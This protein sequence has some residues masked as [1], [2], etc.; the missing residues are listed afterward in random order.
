MR[1]IGILLAL[2]ALLGGC[3]K[4]SEQGETCASAADCTADLR[5]VSSKCVPKVQKVPPATHAQCLTI[6]K[7]IARTALNPPS[8]KATEKFIGKCLS[9]EADTRN[10]LEKA[11]TERAANACM[12][13]APRGRTMGGGHGK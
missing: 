4:L 12:D 9:W 6:S 2:L 8:Q 7:N 11:D 3:R 5:C 13:D 10:C 1:Y